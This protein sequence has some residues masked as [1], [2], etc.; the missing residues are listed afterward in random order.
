M[1]YLRSALLTAVMLGGSHELLAQQEVIRRPPAGLA[2]ERLSAYPQPSTQLGTEPRRFQQAAQLQ[3]Y[4]VP[5][6][7]ALASQLEQPE[8]L[9]PPEDAVLPGQQP[10]LYD[11]LNQPPEITGSVIEL[12]SDGTPKLGPFKSGFFQKLCLSAAWLGDGDDPADL[13]ITEIES[14]ITVAL[15]APIR[16]WPLFITPGYN[17]YLTSDPGGIRDMPPQ[18]HTVYLDFTWAPLFFEHHRLLLTAAPSLYTDFEASSSEAFRL[19]GKALYVWD[20]A[21]DKL[22]FVA[23]VLYLNRDNIRLLPAGGAIWKPT[24]DYNFELIFPKPKLGMRVHVGGG[25]ED[26]LYVAAEFGGNT[27]SIVR[28]TGVEDKVTW[29]DY[30]VVAGYERRLDGGAGYRLEAGYVFSRQVEYASGIGDYDPQPTF[31]IR[32]GITF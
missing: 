24:P 13:G 20:A 12:N 30:R 23:G 21:P 8:L 19:T 3:P 31:L 2:G 32:G 15:P 1:P 28:D 5:G 6:S 11:A 7:I 22:Q 16:E 27:W 4:G 9:P 18:L 17:L 29:S 25:Y 14:S 10:F 26:W